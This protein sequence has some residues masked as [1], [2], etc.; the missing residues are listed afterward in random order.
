VVV[1]Y[2]MVAVC[3]V[4]VLGAIASIH[5]YEKVYAE[6]GSKMRVPRH[7]GKS[8]PRTRPSRQLQALEAALAEQPVNDQ[9]TSAPSIAR[10]VDGRSTSR[11]RHF[12]RPRSDHRDI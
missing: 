2:V 5:S 7:S 3:V 9:P 4:G 12:A 10:T 11:R 1:A 8:R 6:K